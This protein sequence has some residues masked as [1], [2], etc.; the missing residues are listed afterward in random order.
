MIKC[1]NKGTF[2]NLVDCNGNYIGIRI[3]LIRNIRCCNVILITI[4]LFGDNAI[5]E[6]EDNGMKVF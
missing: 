1:Y 3:G 2:P 6:P 4:H 5:I